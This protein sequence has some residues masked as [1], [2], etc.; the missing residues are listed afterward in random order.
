MQRRSNLAYVILAGVVALG[1]TPLM[2]VVDAQARIVFASDR[3]G[4]VIDGLR[5]NEIYV[6]DA[7][8]GNQYKDSPII[9]IRT[10]FLRMAFSYDTDVLKSS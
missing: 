1:L 10:G 6:M 7:D 3:D 8:G 4:L 2:V 5:A 9:T